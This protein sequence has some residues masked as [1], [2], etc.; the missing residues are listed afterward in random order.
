MPYKNILVPY[1]C[2]EPAQ[3]AL[4]EAINLSA[5]LDVPV[6]VTAL[7]V[8]RSIKAE[9]S[10]FFVA[11]QM[12]GVTELDESKRHEWREHYINA[13]RSELEEQVAQFFEGLPDNVALTIEVANGRPGEVIL[14]YAK[15]NKV[16]CIVMG[17][18]GL[19]AVKSAFGSVSTA[20]L[21]EAT[22]VPVL[23][24]R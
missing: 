13:N 1:D 3:R 8:A 17:S 4:T 14:D 16:D 5:G 20:V 21:R 7:R 10:T 9:D 18:R 22:K 19:G 23:I 2:S 12:A 11:A 15:D 6:R 24:V